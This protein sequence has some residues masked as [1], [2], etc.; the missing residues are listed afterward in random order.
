M[1]TR[2]LA[3]AAAMLFTAL[4]SIHAQAHDDWGRGRAYLYE[5]RQACDWGSRWACIRL[6]REIERRRE[7]RREWREHQRSYWSRDPWRGHPW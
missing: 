4:P 6:G 5:L 1:R 3:A 2:M 7:A